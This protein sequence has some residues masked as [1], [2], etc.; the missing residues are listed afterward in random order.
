MSIFLG[1]TGSANELDD[2]EE[3]T[4][5]ALLQVQSGSPGF[6]TTTGRY[7][8]VGNLCHVQGDIQWNAANGTGGNPIYIPLPFT[9]TSCRGAFA[10]GIVSGLDCDADHVALLSPEINAAYAWLFMYKGDDP[11]GGHSHMVASDM[12]NYA[13]RRFSFG[14]TYTTT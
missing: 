6:S 5:T 9:V 8:K 14:G 11:A 10:I 4:F 2:F 1:G 3:G 7:T 13:S 12:R